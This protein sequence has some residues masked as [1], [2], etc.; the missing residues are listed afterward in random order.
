MNADYLSS[1][2]RVLEPI[3]R[4]SEVLFG[5]I[6]ALTF[7]GSLSV[8]GAG[9][10]EVRVMLVGVIGCNLAWALIDAIMYLMGCLVDRAADRQ[11]MAKVLRAATP[12]EA[13]AAIAARL[14]P[15]VAS[16][17]T[18]TD[19]D[20]VRS[21]LSK[22]PVAASQAKLEKED[23]LGAVAV[24]I[25]VFGST[26]PIVL[27]FLLVQDAQTALRVSNSIAVLM[28]LIAGYAF[29]HLVGYRPWLTA[30]SMVLLGC[31][32]VGVTI[33]LGG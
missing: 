32:L 22:L 20:R 10:S 17:L 19:L 4:I 23:W 9:R 13:R 18:T 5:L 26:V 16:A 33:M 12:E 14:P 28:M 3:D 7:T 11:T 31:L 15:L 8:A 24:S 2:K 27:P 21:T 29:G 25:L 1:S 6:M 30:G